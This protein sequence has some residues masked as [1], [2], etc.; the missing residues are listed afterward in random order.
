MKFNEEWILRSLSLVGEVIERPG[1]ESEHPLSISSEVKY[2]WN[3]TSYPLY[4]HGMYRDDFT[5]CQNGCTKLSNVY[6]TEYD[7]CVFLCILL[8]PV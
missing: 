4:L 2:E 6:L 7:L 1:H 5:E 8:V 3:C